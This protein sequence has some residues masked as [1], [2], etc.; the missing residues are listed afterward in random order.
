MKKL[1]SLLCVLALLLGIAVSACAD[2]VDFTKP[3]DIELMA[4]YVMD[5]PDDDP[6]MVYLENKFN[7]HFNLTI[8]NIDNYNGKTP[9]NCPGYRIGHGRY[10]RNRAAWGRVS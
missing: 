9:R 7:V 4:Y 8:T 10:P 3:L 6:I 1:L 2:E 5:I